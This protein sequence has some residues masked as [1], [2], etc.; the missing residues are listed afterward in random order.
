MDLF[1]DLDAQLAAHELHGCEGAARRRLRARFPARHTQ[2]ECA[3]EHGEAYWLYVVEHAG[4]EDPGSRLVR[5]QG[6][7]LALVV[8]QAAHSL[9]EYAGRLYSARLLHPV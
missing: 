2:F 9:E 3:R 7:F 8:A 5:R 1:A 4:D 6:S